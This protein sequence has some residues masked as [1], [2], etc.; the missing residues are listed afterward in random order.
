MNKLQY[1]IGEFNCPEDILSSNIDAW[2]KTLAEFPEKLESLVSHLNNDQLDTRY[3]PEGWTIRQVVHHCADSHH[4]SYTRFKWALTEDKPT[5]KA[6]FEARWAELPD[7]KYEP[8]EL[9]LEFLKVLHARWL[10][11]INSLSASQLE[12]SFVHP[13]TGMSI[14]LKK[15]IGFYAWHCTHHYTHIFNLLKTKNWLNI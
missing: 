4:N 5:I 13:E 7:S 10:I 8:I 1:P 6:Y 9:S 14:T 12:S 2:K 11:L 15:N 3:R